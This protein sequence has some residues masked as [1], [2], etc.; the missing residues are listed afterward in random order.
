MEGAE[1]RDSGGG[2]AEHQAPFR[3]ALGAAGRVASCVL[4]VV[5]V[6]VTTLLLGWVVLGLA[7]LGRG[8]SDDAQPVSTIIA[9]LLAITGVSAWVTARYTASW[10]SIGA[11]IA[12]IVTLV[13]LVAGTWALSAPTQALYLARDI[14]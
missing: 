5:A 8:P 4:L 10:Q 11:I 2:A 13:I 14:A 6:L 1:V 7:L 3:G 12:A 9:A